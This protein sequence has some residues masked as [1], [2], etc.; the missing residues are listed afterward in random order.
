MNDSSKPI[1]VEQTFDV[2][3]EDVWKAITNVDLMRLWFFDNIPSFKP[4]VGFET[5][6]NVHNQGRDFLHL[7]RVTEVIPNKVISYNWKY[8]GYTG[9]S[10]VS[11]ELLIQNGKT[12]IRLTHQVMESFD[13]SIPE[14]TRDSCLQG[15]E[16]FIQERLYNFLKENKN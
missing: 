12:L 2:T 16:Y 1:I 4:K 10:N 5:Q 3:S 6:F 9:D 8:E 7:W 14:F 11:F 15:W 13:Q